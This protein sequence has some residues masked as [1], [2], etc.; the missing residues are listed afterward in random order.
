MMTF[1][2]G[3]LYSAHSTHTCHVLVIAAV[4]VHV[5][6]L[7]VLSG[8]VLRGLLTIHFNENVAAC[9]SVLFSYGLEKYAHFVARK[10]ELFDLL[11]Q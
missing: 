8:Q 11:E 3:G 4:W 5:N 6:T 1:T 10:S 2:T 9:F 7:G